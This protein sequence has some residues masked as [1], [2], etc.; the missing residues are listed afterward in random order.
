MYPVLFQIG[1]ISLYTYGL[2]IALGFIA[3]IAIAKAE[4]RRLGRS[5]ERI[6]DL[7]FFI[8]IAA[9]VGSRVF[10]VLTTPSTFLESPL[11]VFKIWNGGL[12]FYGGF[13][14]ALI[15]VAVYLK[16][17]AMPLWE[18]LDILAPAMAFGHFLGRIGC[19]FA[20]C[21]FGK[22]C[23]LPWAITFTH[24]ETLAPPGI[25]LHP[26]QLYSAGANLAIFGI[27]WLTRTRKGFSGQTALTYVILYGIS[28]GIIEIFR[29]DFRG[30][31]LFGTISIS[32]L[33][34]VLFALAAAVLWAYLKGRTRG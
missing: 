21:C 17:H 32:Q 23:D 27:L 6:T 12:V 29:A 13:I 1:G 28:R 34:S 19:F 11:E 33:I 22:S 14:G 8:L 7:C 15:T 5:P 10:Y 18:T 16:R 24:P 3:G 2:F 31:F 25:A 26:T 30:H 4:A 9:I 20:G